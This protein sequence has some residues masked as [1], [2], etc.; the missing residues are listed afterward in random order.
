MI[1]TLAPLVAA[2]SAAPAPGWQPLQLGGIQG[3]LYGSPPP[4]GSRAVLVVVL[5]GDAPFENPS[6]QYA[7]AKRVATA[8]PGTI[9]AALL[10]PGYADGLGA[11]SKGT[12][13]LATGDNYTPADVDAIDA[14]IERL[15]ATYRP[16]RTILVG[17]SGGA[18]I[19]ADILARH[20]GT[21]HAA[22]LVGCP[23]DV[24]AWRSYMM[25]RQPA[26]VW[27]LPV[28]SLSPVALARDVPAG[29]RI[30]LVVGQLDDVV[31]KRFSDEYAAALQGRGVDATVVAAPNL[32]HN[33]LNE[34]FVLNRF[35]Q[36][37][38]RS[39]AAAAYPASGSSIIST[40]WSASSAGSSP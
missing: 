17:H 38:A 29:D 9:A 35:L 23:C 4:A 39:S 3:R 20:P 37:A 1:P 7:F 19:A 33:I 25:R 11:Q 6:Y 26:P 28:S 40:G 2:A 5:H 34:D 18:A 15:K 24:P 21:A 31:P 30:E 36:F 13:G 16:A 32:P 12:R 22:F 10:R 14:A 8:M 27:T